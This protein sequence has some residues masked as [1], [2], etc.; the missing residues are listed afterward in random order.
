MAKK[1]NKMIGIEELFEVANDTRKFEIELFSAEPIFIEST[2]WVILD[3]MYLILY[4]CNELKVKSKKLVSKIPL[5]PK[6]SG[7]KFSFIKLL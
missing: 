6:I 5:N 2:Y 4:F 7:T 1:E 3:N